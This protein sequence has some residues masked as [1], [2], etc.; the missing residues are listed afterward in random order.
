[1]WA[2]LLIKQK[3]PHFPQRAIVG[4][5]GVVEIA[6]AR[7]SLRKTIPEHANA[8]GQSLACWIATRPIYPVVRNGEVGKPPMKIGPVRF[9]LFYLLS[10]SSYTH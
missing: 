7:L 2:A 1:V 5:D 4:W 6:M 3:Q 8:Q 10:Q 9:K